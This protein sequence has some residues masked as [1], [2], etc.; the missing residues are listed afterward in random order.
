MHNQT[1]LG[2]SFSALKQ[3]HIIYLECYSKPTCPEGIV[4]HF[5]E[6]DKIYI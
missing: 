5:D 3:S 2:Q 4:C 1:L 6:I